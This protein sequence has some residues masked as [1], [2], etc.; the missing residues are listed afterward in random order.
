[1]DDSQLARQLKGFGGNLRRVRVAR[2][3]TQERLAERAELNLRT[4][5]RIEAGEINVLVTTAM[6][7]QKSIDCDWDELMDVD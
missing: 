2:G 7:L 5:Q 3:I 4:V 6:R 1:M